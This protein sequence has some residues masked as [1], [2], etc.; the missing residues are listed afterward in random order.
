MAS[1]AP[2]GKRLVVSLHDLHPG[3]LAD[4]SAQTSFL[5]E[6][7]VETYSILVI[8][9]YHHGLPT[10]DDADTMEWLRREAARGVDLVL[11]GY[12]H[13]RTGLRDGHWFWTRFY[14][15]NE[16]EFLELTDEEAREKLRKGKGIWSREG[17]PL[18]GFIA[19]AWLMPKRLDAV[20]GSMGFAYTTRLREFVG[21]GVREFRGFAVAVL[22]HPGTLAALDV[23]AVEPPFVFEAQRCP[24]LAPEPPSGRPDVPGHPATSRSSPAKGVVTRLSAD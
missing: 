9:E 24:A 20:L 18:H 13:D 2:E 16:A 1:E 15:A 8:P 10:A 23:P 14:T 21:L 19:P 3:S 12:Y 5:R 22:Q 11:H 6:R 17:W 7:G 4:I